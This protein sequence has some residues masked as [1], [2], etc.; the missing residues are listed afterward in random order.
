LYNVRRGFKG[1]IYPVNPRYGEIDGL[2]CF[3][4][5]MDVPD[6]VDMAILFVPA[7]AVP[8]MAAQCARRGIRGVIV[9]SGGFS[10]VGRAAG[11]PLFCWL[12]GR[13]GEMREFKDQARRHGIPVYRE[14]HRT[15]ECMAA[16]FRYRKTLQRRQKKPVPPPA[17]SASQC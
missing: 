11:N 9:E 16:L 3:P 7:A 4:S 6:P 14:L 5:I 10:E 15:V 1:P 13:K 2:P 8:D 12:Q 17:S